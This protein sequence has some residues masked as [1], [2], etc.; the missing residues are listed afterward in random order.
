[1]MWANIGQVAEHK[2]TMEFMP[3]PRR[4]IDSG[5]GKLVNDGLFL[6]ADCRSAIKGVFLGEYFNHF[7]IICV[8][9]EP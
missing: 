7:D 3:S 5:T 1:M 4:S 9:P 8:K 6:F 2:D